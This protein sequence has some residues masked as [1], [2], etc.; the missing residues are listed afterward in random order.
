MKNFSSQYRVA[1]ASS[2][3]VHTCGMEH[4]EI[5]FVQDAFEAPDQQN[6][7]TPRMFFRSEQYLTISRLLQNEQLFSSRAR[8]FVIAQ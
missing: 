7:Y 1:K 2:A 5:Y 8:L 6:I 3:A 4:E